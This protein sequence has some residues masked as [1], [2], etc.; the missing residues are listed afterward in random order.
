MRVI[1]F[2]NQ[3]APKQG[4]VYVITSVYTVHDGCVG[5]QVAVT[6]EKVE[7]SDVRRGS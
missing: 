6:L 7:K 3:K 4:D 5:P 2:N 1:L